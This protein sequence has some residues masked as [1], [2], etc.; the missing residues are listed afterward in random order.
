[1][2]VGKNKQLTAFEAPLAPF[3]AN[4][5]TSKQIA[6]KVGLS[7]RTYERAE[8]IIEQGPEELKEIFV[9]F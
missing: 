8:V 6:A 9:R 4:G 7:S 1:M 3:G 2:L 5:K